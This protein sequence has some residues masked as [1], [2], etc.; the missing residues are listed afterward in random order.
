MQSYHIQ[1]EVELV[2]ITVTVVEAFMTGLEIYKR[3]ILSKHIHC[4]LSFVSLCQP[5]SAFCQ[6][7]VF[8]KPIN[9]F[10]QDES[11]A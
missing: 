2:D 10:S 5:L 7:R 9:P 1:P 4:I 11:T 6:W 3:Y 8:S